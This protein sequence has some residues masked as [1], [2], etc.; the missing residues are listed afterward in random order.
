[1]LQD[2]VYLSV[3][4]VL[5]NLNSRRYVLILGVLDP[6]LGNI[7]CHGKCLEVLLVRIFV[8]LQKHRETC[9][10]ENGIEG[11]VVLANVSNFAGR[12]LSIRSQEFPHRKVRELDS[13]RSLVVDNGD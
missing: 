6:V 3:I 4:T 11:D 7:K 8:Q 5:W 2:M 10:R 12:G 13:F 9:S 1:M